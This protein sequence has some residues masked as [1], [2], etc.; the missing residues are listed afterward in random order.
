[1][2][3]K[4]TITKRVKLASNSEIDSSSW[5]IVPILGNFPAFSFF[6]DI[7]SVSKIDGFQVSNHF[8]GVKRILKKKKK[9]KKKRSHPIS[10]SNISAPPQLALGHR[11]IIAGGLQG[12]Q[13]RLGGTGAILHQGLAFLQL[14]SPV[15]GA[16]LFAKRWKRKRKM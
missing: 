3:C 10:G 6:S 13:K 4:R 9:G 11:M 14:L 7:T 5:L 1:M 2:E 16:K 12:A 8:F 15:L